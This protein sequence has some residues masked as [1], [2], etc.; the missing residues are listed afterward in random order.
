M[1]D[2]LHVAHQGVEAVRT[3]LPTTFNWSVFV[4]ALVLMSA[5]VAHTLRRPL[6]PR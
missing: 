3:V 4:A 6:S 2:A 5:P 1:A